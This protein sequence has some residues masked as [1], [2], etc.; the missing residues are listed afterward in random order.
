MHHGFAALRIIVL[1]LLC[2]AMASQCAHDKEQVSQ[3]HLY[4]GYLVYLA[5]TNVA[6]N[7]VS[8]HMMKRAE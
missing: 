6:D 3:R 5:P 7:Q 2:I 1:N 4:N 8:N